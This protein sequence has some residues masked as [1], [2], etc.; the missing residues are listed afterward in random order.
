MNV[1]ASVGVVVVGAA[2]G[3][4][5]AETVRFDLPGAPLAMFGLSFG[6]DYLAP[7]E[8]SVT[9]A[10]MHLEFNTETDFG[11]FDAADILIQVQA[12]VGEE[13]PW[14]DVQG[15]SLGWSGPGTF[16]ADIETNLLNGPILI[17]E[18]D[19]DA[20]F[21]VWFVRLLN[22]EDDQPLGGQFIGSYVEVDIA[23]VPA[24]ASALALG[25]LVMARRRKR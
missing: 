19:P 12:P 21:S 2:C 20:D 3:R 18:I 4:A 10:R 8:G 17:K 11:S 5:S 22:A 23:P 1:T 24:P 7:P 14:W 15:A 25:M 13:F 16:T 6:A 9:S